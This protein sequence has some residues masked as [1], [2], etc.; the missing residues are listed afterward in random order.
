[1]EERA[2]HMECVYFAMSRP[3]SEKWD[4]AWPRYREKAATV[5]E[6]I[7]SYLA[8]YSHTRTEDETKAAFR[9]RVWE[10]VLTTGQLRAERAF[11]PTLCLTILGKPKASAE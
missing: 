10:A 2:R 7:E 1:S 6:E 5:A 4:S 8:K 3:D 11:D 9:F